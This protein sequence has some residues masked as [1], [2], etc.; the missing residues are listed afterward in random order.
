MVQGVNYRSNARE[1][2]EE[3]GLS[4]FV[5]NED[6]GSVYVEAEGAPLELEKLV[7]WC[8]QGPSRAAVSS[9]FISDG[10]MKNFKGFEIRRW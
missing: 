3:L 5:R 10:E 6:D 1:K 7:A 2:A 4:G 8:R 9:V